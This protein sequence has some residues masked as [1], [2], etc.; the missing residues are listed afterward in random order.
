ML[1]RW[2]TFGVW[3]LVAGSALFWGLRVFVQA[4]AAPPDTLVAQP[5]GDVRGDLTRLFGADAPPPVVEAVA[6]PV[7][8][9][10]FTLV[11]VVSPRNAGAARE[12]VALIAIDGNPAKAY[13]VGMVVDGNTV[14]QTVHA[15]GA[16]LGARGGPALVSLELPPLPPPATG[17]LPS[18]G[19]Q[20]QF[21]GQGPMP[22]RPGQPG[23]LRQMMAPPGTPGYNPAMPGQPGADGQPVQIDNAA[24]QDNAPQMR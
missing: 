7:P 23:P 18:I 6:A 24:P 20:G 1:A 21:P 5:G 2:W 17:T 4:P 16:Q 22:A 19:G 15:R 8:D 11:G 13:R 10:R 3:A 9:T 14:L 12:G